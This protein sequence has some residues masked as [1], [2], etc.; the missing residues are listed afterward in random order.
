MHAESHFIG[1]DAGGDFRVTHQVESMLIQLIECGEG[2]L[3]QLLMDA[4][5]IVEKHD[6]FLAAAQLDALVQGGKKAAPPIG[7]STTCAL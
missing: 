7:I 5:G 2:I 3:L 1:V 6:G 4:W